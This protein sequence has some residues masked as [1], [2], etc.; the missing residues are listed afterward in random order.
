[1]PHTTDLLTHHLEQLRQRLGVA[2][3][4]LDAGVSAERTHFE[5]T[6]VEYDGEELTAKSTTFARAA[7]RLA[8][9]HA[10][11]KVVDSGVALAG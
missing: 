9:A 6:A 1:M 5:L 3:I 8:A 2:S 4:R 11:S 7:T 10:A